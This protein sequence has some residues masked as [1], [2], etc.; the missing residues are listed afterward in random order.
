MDEGVTTPVAASMAAPRRLPTIRHVTAG[1]P[2]G[3]TTAAAVALLPHTDAST[4]LGGNGP[5]RIT[6]GTAAG[7]RTKVGCCTSTTVTLVSAKSAALPASAALTVIAPPVLAAG[8]AS[9]LVLVVL[10]CQAA[11]VGLAP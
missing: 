4:V 2:A 5:P 9:L 8:T 3:T 10:G 1:R 11:P 7:A 6:A